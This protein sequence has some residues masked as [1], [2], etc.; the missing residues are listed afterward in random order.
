MDK[1]QRD[2]CLK[3]DYLLRKRAAQIV[4][5]LLREGYR[6]VTQ[7]DACRLCMLRHNNGS[8]VEVRVDNIGV[9]VFKNGLLKKIELI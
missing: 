7:S 6:L 9:T 5:S 3:R 4:S 2:E 1:A 8:R